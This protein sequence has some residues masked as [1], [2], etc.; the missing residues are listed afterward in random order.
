MGTSSV[1]PCE[2]QI[3]VLFTIYAHSAVHTVYVPHEVSMLDIGECR[4][5]IS[6]KQVAQQAPSKGLL[7]IRP[8]ILLHSRLLLYN[9]ELEILARMVCL[10]SVTVS[11]QSQISLLFRCMWE[12]MLVHRME[13]VGK[14][15]FHKGFKYAIYPILRHLEVLGRLA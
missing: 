2:A 4:R 3:R 1:Q 13:P 15:Q 12:N 8:Q 7:L 10:C 14:T 5:L 6:A 9:I 11:F